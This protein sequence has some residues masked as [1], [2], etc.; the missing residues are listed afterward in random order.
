MM[1]MIMKVKLRKIILFFLGCF[2]IM[3]SFGS[4]FS[5]ELMSKEAVLYLKEGIE[6]QRQGDIDYAISL[7]TKAIYANSN[8][9][10]AYNNRGT[11]YAQQGD[12]ARAEEEYNQALS[13]DPYY[14]IALKNLAI[15]YAERQDW[16]KFFEYWK[17]AE[18]LDTYSPF[19]ID[20]ED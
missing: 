14:A 11:A 1:T 13:I 2:I 20:E 12:I 8:Y 16:E 5:E 6:A 18:G 3:G 4:V 15:I 17:R 10:Q 9:L 19:I 7:Y